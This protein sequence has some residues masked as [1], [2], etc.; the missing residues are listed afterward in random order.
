MR[1][2]AGDGRWK[3]GASQRPYTQIKSQDLALFGS[4]TGR[5]GIRG[6]VS[7]SQSL[8]DCLVLGCKQWM[9]Q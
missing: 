2:E 6:K 5:T 1:P 8:Q 4:G 3:W 9:D 7:D